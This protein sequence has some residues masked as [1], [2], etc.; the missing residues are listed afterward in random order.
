MAEAVITGCWG[1]PG[2]GKD[3]RWSG[4]GRAGAWFIDW[5]LGKKTPPKDNVSSEGL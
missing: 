4:W 3:G 5:I 2:W 1:V